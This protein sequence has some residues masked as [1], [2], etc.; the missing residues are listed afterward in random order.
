MTGEIQSEEFTL[1]IDPTAPVQNLTLVSAGLFTDA[2]FDNVQANMVSLGVID[3]ITTVTFSVSGVRKTAIPPSG[4][5]KDNTKLG[6]FK[7]I[8]HKE[9]PIK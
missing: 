2:D 5:N 3:G 9:S 4:K 6:K 7:K 8:L 1:K